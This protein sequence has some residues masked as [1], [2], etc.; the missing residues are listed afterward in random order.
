MVVAFRLQIPDLVESYEV[1]N[2]HLIDDARNFAKRI[3][4]NK[5]PQ[6]V[7]EIRDEILVVKVNILYDDVKN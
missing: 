1:F 6:V 2:L 5:P 7:F 4:I 3:Q